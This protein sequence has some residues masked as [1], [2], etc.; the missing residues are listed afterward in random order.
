MPAHAI[1]S[2]QTTL[3]HQRSN[4]PMSRC[5]TTDLASDSIAAHHPS[6]ALPIDRLPQA[7]SLSGDFCAPPPGA[8]NRHLSLAALYA[9]VS[10]ERQEKEETIASQVDALQ[11]AAASRGYTVPPEYV[12]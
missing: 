11:R 6:A 8:A 9:R 12:F 10:T 7:L 2:C 3:T 4:G 1:R 5:S